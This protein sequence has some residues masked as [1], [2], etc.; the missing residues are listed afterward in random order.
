MKNVFHKGGSNSRMTQVYVEPMPIPL[1]KVIYDG[2]SEN[3]F[4]KLKLHR[5]PTS[6]MSDL[7]AVRMSLFENSD[8]EEFLF[9]VR[10]FNMHLVEPRMLDMGDKIQY[11][12]TLVSGEALC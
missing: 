1:I 9:F 2:K 11:I 3:D 4:I 8:P 5:Y 12:C 6:S 7:Y 10:N